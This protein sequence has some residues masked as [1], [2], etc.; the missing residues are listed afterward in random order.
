MRH[1]RCRRRIF[2]SRVEGIWCRFS[3]YAPGL[4]GLA[5]QPCS[6]PSKPGSNSSYMIFFSSRNQLAWFNILVL[7]RI[8]FIDP[9]PFTP[10]RLIHSLPKPSIFRSLLY[11][12]VFHGIFLVSDCWVCNWSSI[13]FIFVVVGWFFG[14]CR[15]ILVVVVAVGVDCGQG[16]GGGGGGLYE[17]VVAV[18]GCIILL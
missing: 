18:V 9:A 15:L 7:G 2:V 6:P 16:G 8:C 4:Y 1:Y 10:L 14:S 11:A 17:V 3:T 5:P 12:G 13:G